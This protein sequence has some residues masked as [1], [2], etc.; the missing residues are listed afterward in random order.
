MPTSKC[1]MARLSSTFATICIFRTLERRPGIS[2]GTARLLPR[3]SPG[4]LRHR[5][6]HL[7]RIAFAASLYPRRD[8]S[9]IFYRRITALNRSLGRSRTNEVSTTKENKSRVPVMWNNAAAYL[10]YDSC[11]HLRANIFTKDGCIDS[12]ISERSYRERTLR[13]IPVETM[14]AFTRT[15]RVQQGRAFFHERN[16]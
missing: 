3:R 4:N 5:S 8:V 2:E 11:E 13:S 14:A 16:S 10:A 7:C 9:R 12:T 15:K 6:A 1:Q